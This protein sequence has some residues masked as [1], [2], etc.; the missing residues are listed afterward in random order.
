MLITVVRPRNG[1]GIVGF[2]H[3]PKLFNTLY[4]YGS[5]NSLSTECCEL[6]P[7]T[8]FGVIKK[9]FVQL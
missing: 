7:I 8:S 6:H 5:Y 9:T 4:N 2:S 1:K 3:C